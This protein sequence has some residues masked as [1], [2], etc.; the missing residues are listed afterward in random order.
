MLDSILGIRLALLLGRSVPLPAPAGIMLALSRVEVTNDAESGDG[1]QLTFSC[2]RSILGDYDLMESRSLDPMTRVVIAV[3]F[4]VMPEVLIDGVITHSQF[5]PGNG[6]GQATLTVTGKD[7]T[8]VMDLEEKNE[9]YENQPDFMIVTSV[10]S[11]YARFGLIPAASPTTD[12]P[13]MVERIPRQQ[14]TDLRF[15][16]RLAERNGFVFYIEPLTLG[17][18]KA[19]WGPQIRAG[20][21]QPALSVDLGASTNTKSLSFSNDALAATGVRGVIV[22]PLTKMSIPIPEL[23]SLKVPPLAM[24]PA[25]PFRTTL[26]RDSANQ[27]PATAATRTLAATTN[28]PDSAQANGEVDGAR[29]GNAL[30]ARKLVGVR[31]VGLTNDGFWYV[32]RVTHTL[33]RG[34]YS[35]Q[36][37]LSREGVGTL[38]PVVR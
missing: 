25:K 4:G 19:Y 8:A 20:I 36:F 12:V 16:Q 1:F 10:L 6:P 29:Y 22:E 5:N 37:S 2:S 14:E 15:L 27:N 33:S 31:G 7:L 9:S 26:Q 24:S 11:R 23:P 28:A 35:Q 32:K 38:T 21:P 30:R 17:V 3:V 18:S 13:I 34:E